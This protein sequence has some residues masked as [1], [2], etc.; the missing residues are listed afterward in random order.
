M[1]FSQVIESAIDDIRKEE[2]WRSDTERRLRGIILRLKDSNLDDGMIA[3]IIQEIWAVA[4]A[5][6]G[7]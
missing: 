7:E 2:F 4:S 5:E 3:E 6:Y 1:K